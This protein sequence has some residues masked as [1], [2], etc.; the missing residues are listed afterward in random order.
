MHDLQLYQEDVQPLR[1]FIAATN[2]TSSDQLRAEYSEHFNSF[3][4]VLMVVVQ[5]IEH[6]RLLEEFSP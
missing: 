3:K 1:S 4:Y 2:Y 5:R 6:F